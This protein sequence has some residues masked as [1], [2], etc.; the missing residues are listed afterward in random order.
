MD[1]YLAVVHDGLCQLRQPDEGDV[2]A[3][4]R[5]PLVPALVLFHVGGFNL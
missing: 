5:V 1:S 4:L 3:A 2:V